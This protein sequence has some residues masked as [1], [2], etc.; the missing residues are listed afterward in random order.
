MIAK[1]PPVIYVY[2]YEG[3]ELIPNYSYL[4]VHHLILVEW[5]RITEN[6]EVFDWTKP[7]MV[8]CKKGVCLWRGLRVRRL[9]RSGSFHC[10]WVRIL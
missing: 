3:T 7:S 4:H 1:C 10:W 8:L 2:N 6:H 9:L 5:Y